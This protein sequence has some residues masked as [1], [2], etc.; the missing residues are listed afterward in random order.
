MLSFWHRLW[1]ASRRQSK[2]VP[3]PARQLRAWQRAAR[4]EGWPLAPPGSAPGPPPPLDPGQA[5]EGWLGPFLFHGFGEDGAGGS[6][7]VGSGLLAWRRLER[8]HPRTWRCQYA[9]FDRPGNL[10]LRP[11]APARPRGFYWAFVHP[12]G[13]AS[14]TTISRFRKGLAPG[15]TGLAAEGL[16]LLAV[17][18]PGLARLMGLGDFP[19]MALA[20]YDVAPHGFGDFFES[21]QLFKSQG[22]LGLGVGNVDGTYPR[23]AIPRLR[24][25]GW[26]RP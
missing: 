3:S 12:G 11:G 26:G 18:H 17:S 14:P 15:E 24:P 9:D 22:V 5:K 25:A 13:G 21:P 19:F 8:R 16:Q 23:F 10:R 6:D 4:R 2:Q 1:A 7:Q 20:D